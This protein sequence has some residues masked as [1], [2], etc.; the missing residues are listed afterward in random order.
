MSKCVALVI[1]VVLAGCNA[2]LPAHP[3]SQATDD[4]RLVLEPLTAENISKLVDEGKLEERDRIVDQ[5]G[6]SSL[7]AAAVAYAVD[8]VKQAFADEAATYEAQ[9]SVGRALQGFWTSGGQD[10]LHRGFRLRRYTENRVEGDTDLDLICLFKPSD[11]KTALMI[12]P[13]YVHLTRAKAKILHFDP[14]TFWTAL[15][16]W[17]L[18]TGDRADIRVRVQ[19]EGF[20]SKK[21]G[22]FGRTS[23]ADCSF[24]SKGQ[25]LGTTVRNL[26]PAG[27]FLGV[28]VSETPLGVKGKGN[29]WL[30]VTVTERDPSNAKEFVDRLAAEVASRLDKATN[31]SGS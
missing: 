1:V 17:A 12:Q 7:M 14:R 5:A 20:W 28:P 15:W 24:D 13:A 27:W 11:D 8:A 25:Q 30:R 18:D 22:Q 21:D 10:Q 19:M 9:Y 26:E 3:A 2:L 29:Y 4:E 23:L 31:A 16:I 6:T